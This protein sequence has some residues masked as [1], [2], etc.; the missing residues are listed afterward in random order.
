LISGTGER[1]KKNT[2]SRKT[3]K[4]KR[5]CKKVEKLGKKAFK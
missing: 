5:K 1:A 4:K 3:E 2:G